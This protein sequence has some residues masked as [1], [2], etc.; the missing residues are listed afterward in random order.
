MERYITVGE[1]RSLLDTFSDDA[2]VTVTCENGGDRHPIRNDQLYDGVND[3]VFRRRYGDPGIDVSFVELWSD[4]GADISSRY[5][6]EDDD[7]E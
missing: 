7:D 4:E 3:G 2:F 1:L 6:N 5:E